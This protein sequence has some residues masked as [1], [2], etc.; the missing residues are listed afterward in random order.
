MKKENEK[1]K[2]YYKKWLRVTAVTVASVMVVSQLVMHFTAETAT[3]SFGPESLMDS[4]VETLMADPLLLLDAV[5]ELEDQSRNQQR[6]LLEA[7]DQAELLIREEQYEDALEPVNYLMRHMNLTEEEQTQMKMTQTALYFSS[8]QFEEARKG[9]T[10]LIQENRHENGYYYFMRSVCGIQE[11]AYQSARDDLLMALQGGY[12]DRALCYVHLAFCENYLED[13]DKVLEYAAL[14]R[15][16]K[17]EEIYRPTLI[18]LQAVASL[19]TEKFRDSIDYIT[20]L[21][22]TEAYAGNGDLYFYRGVGYLTLENYQ[23][24][25]D[26][27]Q[28]ALECGMTGE[29]GG[30]AQEKES[31]DG[32]APSMLYYNRGVAALG[33]N[34]PKEAAEDLEKVISMNDNRELVEASKELMEVIRSGGVLSGTRT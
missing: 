20:E 13:Y 21:L 1:Q 32:S 14:A 11:E 33:L 8:G 24:A 10:E 12:E 6:K 26:D 7:C 30:E 28:K 15:A 16:E 3:A 29:A 4:Q 2:W 17:A 31:R 18:Y 27:F 34:R 19:K 22:E 9:C 23:D 25:Y 5:K